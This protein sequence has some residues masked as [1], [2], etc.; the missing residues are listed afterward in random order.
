MTTTADSPAFGALR[1]RHFAKVKCACGLVEGLPSF[2]VSRLGEGEVLT[3][4][5]TCTCG[6]TRRRYYT[7]RGS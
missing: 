5:A 7:V 3:G 1:A 6:E 4:K 2:V